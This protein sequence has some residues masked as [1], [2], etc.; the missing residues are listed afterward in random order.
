[1]SDTAISF[2]INNFI[3]AL[4]FFKESVKHHLIEKK[5]VQEKRTQRTFMSCPQINLGGENSTLVCSKLTTRKII[6]I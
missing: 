1:M 5:I 3:Q 6:I 4:N 2:H